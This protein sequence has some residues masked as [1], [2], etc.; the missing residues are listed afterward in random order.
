MERRR[1]ARGGST[2]PEGIRIG[3]PR[4]LL[5][6]WFAP[7]WEAFL[8]A[9]GGVPVVSPPT[10]KALLALGQQNAPEEVCLPVK[11]FLGHALH[12]A[13]DCDL[14]LVPHLVS[15][16]EAAFTCPKFM[17][18]P[19]LVRTALPGRRTVPFRVDVRAGRPWEAAMREVACA[20]G[21]RGRRVERAWRAAVAA[22][23]DYE[24]EFRARGEGGGAF[25]AVLGHPYCLYDPFLN[26]DL[27]ARLAAAGHRVV[28]PEMLPAPAIERGLAELP[29]ALF[30]S[31]GR[32]QIGAANHLLAAGECLGL[33]HVTAFA[34]GPESLVGELIER[35]AARHRVPLLRLVLDEHTGEAGLLTRIE[36]FV[37]MLGR[38]AR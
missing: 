10:N 1:R 34:C 6:H 14:L 4:A 37:E 26:M 16:E 32:R 5:Y 38:R 8:R 27:L 9:L 15:L 30:W 28:T 11:L 7:A 13:G 29:K 31:F 17:G 25:L 33:I 21:L 22:Q 23:R 19:D 3:L 18:L 12:L 24:E 35:T 2:L 20:L 36:A